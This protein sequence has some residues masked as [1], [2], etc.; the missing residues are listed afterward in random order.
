MATISNVGFGGA[1]ILGALLLAPVAA[2]ADCAA[3]IKKMAAAVDG[4]KEKRTKELL[5]FDVQ[6]AKQE[7]NEGDEDECKEAMDH[8][9][10]LV[11]PSK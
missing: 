7:L 10:T 5:A 8:A 3:D 11:A 2:R 4:V 6:R 9:K 1:L